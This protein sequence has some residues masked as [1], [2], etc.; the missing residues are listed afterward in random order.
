MVDKHH[1][2]DGNTIPRPREKCPKSVALDDHDSQRIYSVTYITLY[3][4]C[5]SQPS[6]RRRQL[7]MM[8]SKKEGPDPLDPLCILPY[9][10]LPSRNGFLE[11]TEAHDTPKQD[12]RTTLWVEEWNTPVKSTEWRDRGIIQ[13]EH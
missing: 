11:S 8:M 4:L 10:R 5:D 3:I 13:N 12:A 9:H 1:R 6:Q 7:I 2:K